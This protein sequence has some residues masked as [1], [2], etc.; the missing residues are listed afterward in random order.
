M[1]LAF[2]VAQP[3]P[4]FAQAQAK[5]SLDEALA[6]SVERQ[7]ALNAFAR[8]ARAAEEAAVAARQLP[9]PQLTIGIQNL[10]VT[11]SEAFDLGADF[12]TMKSIGIMRT[13]VR[14]AKR[15]AAS[16]RYLAEAAVS[17]AEQDVLARR[18]QREVM[19]GWIAIIEAQ[20]KR[21]VLG[22]LVEKLEARQSLVEGGILDGSATPA[23]VIAIEADI[24]AARG[25][26]LAAKDAE[27]AGRAMLA[28][29]IGDAAQRPLSTKQLPICRPSNKQ[30][31]L[32]AVA[33]H[34]LIEVARRRET[35]AERSI[36]IARAERKPDWGWSAMYG[37]RGG[38]RSDMVTLQVTID[39][40]FNKSRLQ[41][42]RIAEASELA[43]AARDRAED[44]RR[45]VVSDF[46]QAWAQ[47]SEANARLTTALS[48]T[49]PALE[50][51]ERALEARVAGGQPAVTDVQAASERTTRTVLDAI[52]QR[53]ALARA[54]ADLSFYAEECA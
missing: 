13:Q 8:T 2:A 27:T 50:A 19:L 7:P 9:D 33:E 5:L 11:G 17:L 53:A 32:A 54:S 34:P 43:A 12:M 47:W 25:E 29:W 42:R 39:L 38:G 6:L 24:S 48:D 20:Q 52:E 46:E 44:T 28:R 14:E 37:Q 35:V 36:D 21:E 1:A 26:M 41:N 22:L 3:Q 31:A 23:D 4:I 30:L 40:P 16:A 51:V 10:P 49:L 15:D 45:E 18:I